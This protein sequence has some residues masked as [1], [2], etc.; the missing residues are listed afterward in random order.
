FVVF[1]TDP[2]AT[3]EALEDP[4][5]TEQAQSLSLSCKSYIGFIDLV[6]DLPM[7]TRKY[8]RCHC[9]VLS[10]GLAKPLPESYT[11]EN[12]CIPVAPATHPQGRPA[13]TAVPPLPWDNLYVHHSSLF[14]LRVKT[15]PRD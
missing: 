14:T 7:E 4:I 15:D 5:A 6:L 9:F 2:V 1:K 12:M 10:Q 8:H 13:I 3:L 11:D